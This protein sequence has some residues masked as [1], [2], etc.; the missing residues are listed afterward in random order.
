M[1]APGGGGYLQ[2]E[3]FKWLPGC[4]ANKT[5]LNLRLPAPAWGIPGDLEVET[6][7]GGV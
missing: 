7:E 6:G 5:E 4:D 1:H 3:L 2:R